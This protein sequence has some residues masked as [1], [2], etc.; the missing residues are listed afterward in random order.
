M[1]PC[2]AVIMTDWPCISPGRT[3]PFLQLNLEILGL[4]AMLCTMI[5][6][7][8]T[9]RTPYGCRFGSARLPPGERLWSRGRSFLRS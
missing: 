7:T 4:S 3:S 9:D 8:A 1:P 5:S 6:Q 2:R